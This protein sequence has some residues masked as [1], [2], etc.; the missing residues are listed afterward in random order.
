M[1]TAAATS[2]ILSLAARGM[3]ATELF[4]PLRKRAAEDN[5]GIR[6]IVLK[7]SQ[8]KCVNSLNYCVMAT[9]NVLV[10]SISDPAPETL[11]SPPMAGLPI[12]NRPRIQTLS[13]SVL[14][15]SATA[16]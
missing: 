1:A 12:E 2:A 13:E 11:F 3:F 16:F 7:P 5:A 4:V 10:C 15:E 14:C 6:G 8:E 9:E